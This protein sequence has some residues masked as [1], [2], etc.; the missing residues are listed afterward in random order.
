MGF[1]LL[2]ARVEDIKNVTKR[3]GKT[4]M[5]DRRRGIKNEKIRHMTKSVPKGGNRETW[6]EA[7]LEEIRS[8]IFQ[9]RGK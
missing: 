4:E 1:D 9:I 5:A 7:V 6:E 3:Y 8:Y 2:R